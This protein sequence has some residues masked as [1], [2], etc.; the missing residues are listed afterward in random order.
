MSKLFA[1]RTNLSLTLS[2][3]GC[4]RVRIMHA[5][6]AMISLCVSV[7]LSHLHK[8]RYNTFISDTVVIVVVVARFF[9]SHYSSSSSQSPWILSSFLLSSTHLFI[10]SI[11]VLNCMPF[12]LFAR[13]AIRMHIHFAIYKLGW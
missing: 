13:P 2:P 6:Q 8:L 7:F 12:S 10:Y 4:E 5:Q 1:I 3:L 11:F 9:S